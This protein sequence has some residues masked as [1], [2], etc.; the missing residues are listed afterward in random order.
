MSAE[1]DSLRIDI[2]ATRGLGAD[3]AKFLDGTTLAEIES[4]A[5]ALAQVI[6]ASGE[7]CEHD[8]VAGADVFTIAL[9]EK[10]RRKATLAALFS[11]RA[12]QPR[13]DAGRYARATSFDGGARQPI[14]AAKSPEQ[15]HGELIGQLAALRRIYDG[16][17]ASF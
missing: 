6:G 7:R 9:Q 5:D 2:A 1:L 14:P 17:G 3:A 8:D 11:G 10:A 13:D 12:A 16:G 4:Q 15:A